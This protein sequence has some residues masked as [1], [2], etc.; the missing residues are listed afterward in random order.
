MKIFL[1]NY[2]FIIQHCFASLDSLYSISSAQFIDV[3]HKQ[4]L[5]NVNISYAEIKCNFNLPRD[6]DNPGETSSPKFSYHNVIVLQNEQTF[7][8]ISYI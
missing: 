6:W 5:P 8:L 7:I 1:L 2:L 4:P 3:Y